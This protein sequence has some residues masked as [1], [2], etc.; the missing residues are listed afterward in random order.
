VVYEGGR[1]PIAATFRSS[2]AAF[3]DRIL[4][5]SEEGD[6]FVIRAGPK[7]EVL[8]SNSVGEPVWAS[9]AFAHKTIYIRGAQHLF[10]IRRP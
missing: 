3:G 7:H 8:H 10:A 6:T 4:E 5:T 2:L 9:L 1:P